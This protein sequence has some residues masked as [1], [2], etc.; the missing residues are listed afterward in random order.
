MFTVHW[1]CLLSSGSKQSPLPSSLSCHNC[2]MKQVRPEACAQDVCGLCDLKAVTKQRFK[3]VFLL[4]SPE[5][6][7]LNIGKFSPW[8]QNPPANLNITKH[9][10]QVCPGKPVMAQAFVFKILRFQSQPWVFLS[11]LGEV[12][13]AFSGWDVTE[14]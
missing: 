6:N 9:K 12:L 11:G 14:L 5:D 3:S 13:S 7:V 2:L 8:R 10:I 4:Q 1:R